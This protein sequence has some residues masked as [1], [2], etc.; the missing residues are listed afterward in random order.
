MKILFKYLQLL[1]LSMSGSLLL[2]I[3]F[4][5]NP[6]IAEGTTAGK[7]FWFHFTVL[8][9]AISVL[10]TE[11]TVRK[12]N[13]SFTLP[14]GLLLLFS[15]LILLGYNHELDPEPEK[16]LFIGQ[17]TLL[18]FMLRAIMQVHPELKLFFISVI[19]CTGLFEAIWGMGQLHSDLAVTHPLLKESSPM[20]NPGPYAGYLAMILPLCL[21]LILRLRNCDKAAFWE[22]RT[23]LFYLAAA[24]MTIILIALP[25]GMSRP[26]WLAAIAACCWVFFL[27][28]SGWRLLKEKF[29]KHR[30]VAVIAFAFV[31]IILTALP[32]IGGFVHPDK[33]ASR[34]LMWN[35][36]VKAILEH[37]FKGT[38]LGGFPV[39]YA[40]A[41]ADYFS[42]GK[43]SDMER[44]VA[45][46]PEFPFNEYLH[47]GLE[48]GIFGLLLFAL[49]I[50]FTLYYGLKNRQIGATGGIIAILCFSMYSYPLQLQSFWVL[51][52]FFAAISVTKPGTSQKSSPCSFP[53]FGALVALMACVIF[54]NQQHYY[55]PYLEWKT[56][57]VLTE[58]KEYNVAAQGYQCLY[59]LLAHKVE[60]LKEGA[61]CLQQNRQYSDV[62]IWTRR[63]LQKSAE[64]EIHYLMA[65]SFQQLGFYK[66]AE[67]CLLQCKQI[68][69]E[70]T[71]TYYLL[72]KLYSETAYFHPDK[73]K[74][75][76]RY[77]FATQL[78]DETDEIRRIKEEVKKILQYIK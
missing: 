9:L 62:I 35:V 26:A 65:E 53:Y 75:A 1:S 72:I 40:K 50:G 49:W 60:F 55:K 11:T 73:L 71:K 66:Q 10:F 77:I 64:P 58:K 28:K 51:L 13:F 33:S 24:G 19:I 56:L 36:T 23:M 12:S 30:R 37:P 52:I 61:R 3:V 48:Y 4:A 47:M 29:T 41:Q 59:P 21:N 6:E 32:R 67:E 15:G 8:L 54:C 14:D 45:D 44:R 76:A 2:C 25:G 5:A 43:A 18:W 69:P 46:C 31:F 57:R 70:Q 63:A 78:P 27:R 16:L 17:L 34:M 38:G 20:F 7:V 74:Q 22:S 68:L 39:S 42:S